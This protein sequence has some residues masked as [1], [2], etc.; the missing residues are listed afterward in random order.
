MPAS[1]G[2]FPTDKICYP[3]SLN[4]T[5]PPLY[6][7]LF[8]KPT[9]FSPSYLG[10]HEMKSSIIPTNQELTY[11]N[12]LADLSWSFFQ[13]SSKP[14]T[15]HFSHGEGQLALSS[16]RTL[17]MQRT[18]SVAESLTLKCAL[19]SLLPLLKFP[20]DQ[21][22]HRAYYTTSPSFPQRE[23][24]IRPIFSAMASNWGRMEFIV[25]DGSES[26]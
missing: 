3:S 25:F 13:R 18:S 1:S 21:L 5:Q 8:L 14:Y 2:S 20:A 26:P 15:L 24:H 9:H 22:R 7:Q 10:A 19:Q 11:S 23:P 12:D 16:F 4:T 6:S 17:S